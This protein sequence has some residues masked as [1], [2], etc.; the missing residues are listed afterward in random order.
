MVATLHS[1][2]KNKASALASGTRK[3]CLQGT[4]LHTTVM[5]S[6]TLLTRN[7]YY[8]FLQSTCLASYVV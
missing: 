4:P 2:W 5:C 3:Y 1:P 8:Y 6:R 7:F